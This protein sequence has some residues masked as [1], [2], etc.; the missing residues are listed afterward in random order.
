MKQQ[1]RHWFRQLSWFLSAIVLVSCLQFVNVSVAQQKDEK[2]NSEVKEDKT[3][4]L[5]EDQME[6]LENAFEEIDDALDA[7]NVK[8]RKDIAEVDSDERGKFYSENNPMIEFGPKYLAFYKSTVEKHP[9]FASKALT[10]LLRRG[11]SSDK[12]KAAKLVNENHP[13][14]MTLLKAAGAARGVE[15]EVVDRTMELMLENFGDQ[16]GTLQLIMSRAKGKLQE[17]AMGRLLTDFGDK[18]E[19]APALM[20]LSRAPKSKST[21]KFLRDVAEQ[22]TNDQ[23]KGMAH[24]ILAKYLISHSPDDSEKEIASMLESVMED[25]GD[26]IYSEARGTTLNS[27]AKTELFAFQNLRIGKMVPE[28]EGEDIDG[29]SFKLSDYRGKVVLIDFW[30]DW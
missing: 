2:A 25:Y 22:S 17:R 30:G 15:A 6:E 29:K 10:L 12:N 3:K 27:V 24:Y 4:E 13:K 26:E 8:F 23:V 21:E 28:I 18:D 19:L 11:V 1:S 14:D 7:A 5:T 20:R 16:V 9:K